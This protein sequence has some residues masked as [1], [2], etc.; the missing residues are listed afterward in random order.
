LLALAVALPAPAGAADA[1]HGG[2]LSGSGRTETLAY[3]ATCDSD[4]ALVINRR[5][6]SLTNALTKLEVSASAITATTHT[7]A[8]PTLMEKILGVGCNSTTALV[9]GSGTWIQSAALS[10]LASWTLESNASASGQGNGGTITPTSPDKVWQ[11]TNIC[12]GCSTTR[13]FNFSI[14]SFSLGN[15][16]GSS[17]V[18]GDVE[19][20]GTSINSNFYCSLAGEYSSG[21]AH[22]RGYASGTSY[23]FTSQPASAVMNT[24]SYFYPPFALSAT[25]CIGTVKRQSNSHTY[26][27]STP[28]AGTVTVTDAGVIDLIPL[29]DWDPTGSLRRGWWV[30][31]A[32]GTVRVSN[33]ATAPTS[34]ST[35]ATYDI[36][37]T[38]LGGSTPLFAITGLDVDQDGDAT[39]NPLVMMADGTHYAAW[40]SCAD[41]DGDGYG[42]T[43]SIFCASHGVDC[44]DGSSGVNPGATEV[45]NDG[46]DQDCSG[47]DLVQTLSRPRPASAGAQ[48]LQVLRRLFP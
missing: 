12:P 24:G 36:G 41:A 35:N 38:P 43:D 8:S 44:D 19:A 34:V 14:G 48:A 40:G 31:K 47:G 32:D 33:S 25:A 37:S 45:A 17:P 10:N 42:S 39:D 9:S 1:W 28:I 23:A 29:G 5:G 6:T 15:I 22:V 27:L 3:P 13:L 18:A 46:I 7:P 21:Q 30:N 4:T 2:T 20:V 16:A 11:V 26:I